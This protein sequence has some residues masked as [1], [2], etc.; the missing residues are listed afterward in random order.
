MDQ[1][2]KRINLTISEK[3]SLMDDIIDNLRKESISVS[4]YLCNLAI[5]DYT[6][7]SSEKQPKENDAPL[8]AIDRILD[9]MKNTKMNLADE[10]LR[11]YNNRK[12]SVQK[13]VAIYLGISALKIQLDNTTTIRDLVQLIDDDSMIHSKRD[14]LSSIA[15]DKASGALKE[16]LTKIQKEQQESRSKEELKKQKEEKERTET[17]EWKSK[18][19]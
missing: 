13:V 15:V 11:L 10:I 9:Y 1:K 12:I 16:G 3:Y 19:P 5:K 17:E 8:P 4:D 2:I 6:S 7:K 14:T 18:H